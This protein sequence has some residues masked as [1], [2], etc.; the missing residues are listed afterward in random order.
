MALMPLNF[1][2]SFSTAALK[3]KK[4]VKISSPVYSVKRWND[5]IEGLQTFRQVSKNNNYTFISCEYVI[6]S[7]T[8]FPSHL[9]GI[10]LGRLLTQTRRAYQK[11]LLTSCQIE[12]L[13]ECQ[14]HWDYET[15][16][17]NFRYLPA[18]D[19]YKKLHGHLR[20]PIKPAFVIPSES[21][22]P[23]N[24]WGMKLG[25]Q[26]RRWRSGKDAL[27]LHIIKALEERDFIWDVNEDH[28]QSIVN[29][30]KTYNNLYGNLLVPQLFR[31][32]D[33]APWPKSTHG[34]ALGKYIATLRIQRGMDTTKDEILDAIEFI[35]DPV[36]Y[37]FEKIMLPACKIYAGQ[38][39]V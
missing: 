1:V 33:T 30:L 2:S 39:K 11:G 35:W 32:P 12:T 14:M 16:Y 4:Q 17:W 38:E 21:Q 9:Q 23:E 22:W 15:Y 10:K 25:D 36:R 19:V 7:T 20:V 28:F 29:A 24:L 34:Y 18:L 27:P 37:R 31:I 6:P 8:A 26:V 3:Y 5:I 13:G